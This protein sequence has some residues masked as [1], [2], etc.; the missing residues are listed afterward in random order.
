ML[1]AVNDW[2]SVFQSTL[3]VRGATVDD[4][5]LTKALEISIHAPR[6]G[7]DQAYYDA[8]DAQEISIHAPRTG[9]DA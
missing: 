1:F 6:T 5:T 3:P 2:V 4:R 7:S 8:L 9:S